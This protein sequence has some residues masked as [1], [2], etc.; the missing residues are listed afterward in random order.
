MRPRFR[1]FLKAMRLRPEEAA[2][3][4]RF[5]RALFMLGACTS[6]GTVAAE[7]MLIGRAGAEF[8]PLAFMANQA[9][10]LL[11]AAAYLRWGRDAKAE[12]TFR[13]LGLIAGLLATFAGFEFQGHEVNSALLLFAVVHATSAMLLV[14]FHNVRGLIMDAQ[15]TKQVLPRILPFYLVGKVA[16]GL[17]AIGAGYVDTSMWGAIYGLSVVFTSWSLAA[18]FRTVTAPPPPPMPGLVAVGYGSLWR[19]P[20]PR[21]ALI[22]CFVVVIIERTVEMGSGVLLAKHVQAPELAKVLGEFTAVAAILAGLAQAFIVA[23]LVTYFGPARMAILF[24]VSAL[25]A[26]IGGWFVQG[27]PAALLLR[28]A[29]AFLPPATVDPTYGLLE[30]SLPVR[31]ARDVRTLKTGMMRPIAT[32]AVAL[33]AAVLKGWALH[34]AV[35]AS[36][37]LLWLA[38]MGPRLYARACLELVKDRGTSRADLR[39]YK[40]PA[41]E[42]EIWREAG[43]MLKGEDLEGADAAL[44]LVEATGTPE[45]V[46]CAAGVLD[47]TPSSTVKARAIEVLGRL[48]WKPDPALVARLDG[49]APVVRAEVFLCRGTSPELVER[50]R[51]ELSRKSGSFA[52]VAAAGFLLDSDRGNPELVRTL[53][54]ALR[55]P[56]ASRV[57]LA[58]RAVHRA[59]GGGVPHEL[60]IQASERKE[61]R[62]RRAAIGPLRLMGRA[63]RLEQMALTDLTPT[64]RAAAFEALLRLDA[65]AAR[66]AAP[67]L[68]ADPSSR[69]REP[70]AKVLIGAGRSGMRVLR[71]LARDPR[72]RW[73]TRE[74]AL[75]V[76]ARTHTDSPFHHRIAEAEAAR[77]AW[78]HELRDRL[79]QRSRSSGL[80]LSRALIEDEVV[81]SI[82]LSLRA[83]TTHLGEMFFDTLVEA[84]R[85]PRRGVRA[86]G[87]ESLASNLYGAPPE[88]LVVMVRKVEYLARLAIGSSLPGQPLDSTQARDWGDGMIW[89]PEG[90]RSERHEG[91]PT[92][93]PEA[94]ELAEPHIAVLREILPKADPYLTAALIW[95]LADLGAPTTVEGLAPEIASHGIVRETL[96]WVNSRVYPGGM[97]TLARLA[98]LKGT[99]LFV[100]FGAEELHLVA[101]AARSENFH[102]GEALFRQGD[103]AAELHVIVRGRVRIQLEHA[104]A[105]TVLDTLGPEDMLG[106]QGVFDGQPRSASAV[107]IEPVET[108]SLTRSE[109]SELLAQS[110]AVALAFLRTLSLRLRRASQQLAAARAPR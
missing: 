106:E 57:R 16:G 72:L 84:I 64:V 61:L 80:L 91:P 21:W 56:S 82:Y 78:L 45:A 11:V 12:L 102:P 47:D 50:A 4:R 41:V 24:P 97:P 8:L 94:R 98:F 93:T 5:T 87:L 32:V 23:P 31:M 33:T 9:A 49:E 30:G 28:F 65:A 48:G 42:A 37:V 74:E 59:G 52:R 67:K 46:K 86:Q 69:V 109:L 68:L 29:H 53:S 13:G 79:P 105:C 100:G 90:V 83:L 110:P 17:L 3:A 51:F 81:T 6:L 88:D 58:L 15:T 43:R 27:L 26:L 40:V 54:D 63:D 77:A 107:A 75:L 14:H 60:V 55:A 70:V 22:A 36:F 2:H 95:A 20:F 96:D 10:V 35:G 73:A 108:L 89:L 71:R 39:N 18:P 101:Q 38:S 92:N 66:I 104:G 34:V 7:S 1:K 76:I 44:D 103:P 25:A 19:N 85:S 99:E 62:V